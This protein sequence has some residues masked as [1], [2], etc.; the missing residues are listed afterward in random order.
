MLEGDKRYF[1]KMVLG[2]GLGAWGPVDLCFRGIF[3][4]SLTEEVLVGSKTWPL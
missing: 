2:R 1:K 4:R 3:G